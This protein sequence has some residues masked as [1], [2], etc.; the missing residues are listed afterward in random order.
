M[1]DYTHKFRVGR[2]GWRPRLPLLALFVIAGMLTTGCY[3]GVAVESDPRGGYAIDVE[4]R[5]GVSIE[6]A[7]EDDRGARML[8]SVPAGRS[9][10]F[11]VVSPSSVS[12]VIVAMPQGRAAQ[13]RAVTLWAAGP[14]RVVFGP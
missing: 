11:L 6:V 12:V 2:R 10:R 8:G 1:A 3:R 13:R 9:E 7:F 4:N 14:V 5:F